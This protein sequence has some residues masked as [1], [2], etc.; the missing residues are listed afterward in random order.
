MQDIYI[1]DLMTRDVQCVNTDAAMEEV[2]Q[3]MRKYSFSCIVI[4]DNHKPVGIITER[5]MVKI[6]S[7]IVAVCPV[8]K[9]FVKDFMAERLVCL[10]E[11]ATLY[12]ALVI[13]NTRRIRHLPVIN[14]SGHLVGLVTQ[15]DISQAHFLAVEKQRSVIEQEIQDRTRE[16]ADANEE[17]K[18]L[19]L[20]D[21][22]LRI[23]NRRAMAVDVHFTHVNALRYCRPYALALIEIDFFKRYSDCYGVRATKEVLLTVVDLMRQTLRSSDRVYRYSEQEFLALMTETTLFEAVEAI[24][25][26]QEN[27]EAASIEHR[28]S[29]YKVITLSIGIGSF[30]ENSLV[31]SEVEEGEGESWEGVLAEADKYLR[32]AK[33]CGRNQVIWNVSTPR[34]NVAT[35]SFSSLR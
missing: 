29:P 9:L 35:Q 2:I 10:H 28:K 4:V 32:E 24:H 34:S 5:D 15:T 31:N 30:T 1:R 33:E 8:G 3:L 23:G 11:S 27:M 14:N 22:L 18:N 20:Q 12:E 6:L 26:V 25:R 16:L 19:A 17:L 21:S 7:E 13:A